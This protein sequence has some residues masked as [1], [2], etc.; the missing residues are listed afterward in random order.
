MKST[1]LVYMYALM[2]LE[3]TLLGA[4]LVASQLTH[5]LI[6]LTDAYHNLYNIISVLLL[7]ISFKVKY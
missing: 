4:E 6:I 5:S 7:V 1:K 2:S 3:G